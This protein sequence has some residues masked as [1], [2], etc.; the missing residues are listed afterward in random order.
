[1]TGRFNCQDKKILASLFFLEFPIS[2]ISIVFSNATVNATAELVTYLITRESI[3]IYC[4]QQSAFKIRT[5]KNR[6]YKYYITN[7]QLYT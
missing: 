5:S 1:M 2:I 6:N 4:M 7:F 3:F